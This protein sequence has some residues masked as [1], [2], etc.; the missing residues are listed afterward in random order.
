MHVLDL[1]E[2]VSVLSGLISFYRFIV[3]CRVERSVVLPCEAAD[4]TRLLNRLGT[5]W[6]CYPRMT[7]ILPNQQ[8]V[9]RLRFRTVVTHLGHDMETVSCYPPTTSGQSLPTPICKLFSKRRVTSNTM[10]S[11]YKKRRADLPMFEHSRMELS[12]FLERKFHHETS[13]SLDSSCTH[14]SS[15]T[16]NRMKSCLLALQ[17][18]ESS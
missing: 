7:T 18:F 16:S 8:I 13:V 6:Q 12:S 10:W 17:C 5:H 1:V 3:V 15:N 2:L 14:Q 9:G 4:P 11:P